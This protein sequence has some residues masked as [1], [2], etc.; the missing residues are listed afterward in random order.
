MPKSTSFACAP[1][2]PDEDVLRL[3]V[4]VDDPGAVRRVSAAPASAPTCATS[5]SFELP[6]PAECSEGV[7]LDQLGDQKGAF[8]VARELVERGD[9]AVGEASD[10]LRLPGDARGAVL[11]V[12]HLDRDGPLQPLVPGAVDG[13]EA[14]ASD[15]LLD[16]ES[17]QDLLTDHGRFEFAPDDLFL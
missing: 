13:P 8:A 7:S 4:A 9:V 2:A 17:P 16:A 12:D 5:R 1:P 11:A 15:P 14:A 3:H 6:A 10:S